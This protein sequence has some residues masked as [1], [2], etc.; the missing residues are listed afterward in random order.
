MARR[1]KPWFRKA[2]KAWFVTIN[3]ELQNLGPN[4]AEAFDRFYQLDGSATR[5]HGGVGLGLHI[6]RGL[7]E[8]LGGRIQ[9]DSAPSVGSIFTVTIP[10]VDEDRG[11]LAGRSSTRGA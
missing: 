9:V 1:P 6:V 5:M 11:L 7:V 2:R 4:K 10:L 8:S 3:G